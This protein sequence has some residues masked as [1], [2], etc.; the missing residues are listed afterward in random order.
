MS[1]M[2]DIR[3]YTTADLGRSIRTERKALGL[4]Q[5]SLARKAQISRQT[6]IELEQGKN[7]SAYVLM[8]VLAAIG[9]ALVVT[10]ARPTVEQLQAIL[11]DDEDEHG[12]ED[13]DAP[14]HDAPRRRG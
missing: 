13:K 12:Y 10:D 11:A 7:T 4:T 9:K 3:A 6:L 14:R 2:S 5:E 8:G 1:A